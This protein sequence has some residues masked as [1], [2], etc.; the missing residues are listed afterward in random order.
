MGLFRRKGGGG[1]GSETEGTT[2]IDEEGGAT[3]AVEAVIT[4]QAQA[5]MLTHLEMMKEIVMK[6]RNEPGYAKNMYKECPR[7]QYL[8]E[9]NP[10]I[11]PVFE[12]PALVR[13]NFETVYREAGGVLPEEEAHAVLAEA[14]AKQK[15]SW[16]VRIANSPL[17]KLIKVALFFKKVIGCIAGG[18]IAAIGGCIACATDCCTD[19]CC[20][21]ALEQISV[22]GDG[23]VD[24]DDGDYDEM[25]FGVEGAPPDPNAEALN[26]AAEY[27]EDPDVQE[28]MQRLL[29]DPDNL[30]DAIENDTELRTLRDSNPLCAELMQDPETMKILVDPDNLRALGE[31]PQ[32]IELDFAD[33]NGFVPDTDFIDIEGGGGGG[34]ETFDV[35]FDP[36]ADLEFNPDAAAD[37]DFDAEFDAEAEAEELE[38]DDDDE[39]EGGDDNDNDNDFDDDNDGDDGDGDGDGDDDGNDDGDDDGAEEEEDDGGWEEDLEMEDQDI[40]ADADTNKQ[41]EASKGK[42]R[43]K[44]AAEK[45][46]AKAGGVKGMIA[47]MGVAATDLI[48]AQ[49]VGQIFGDDLPMADLLG[50]GGGDDI[51]LGGM[52]NVADQAGDVGDLVNDDIADVMDDTAAEVVDGKGEIKG[53]TGQNKHGGGLAQQDAMYDESGRKIYVAGGAAAAAVVAGGAIMVGTGAAAGVAGGKK[54]KYSSNRSIEKGQID[55]D[56]DIDSFASV[57]SNEDYDEDD[58]EDEGNDTKKDSGSD[59]DVDEEPK[60]PKSKKK[61]AFGFASHRFKEI[62]ASTVTQIKETVA[63]TFLGEDFGEMLVE[64]MEE[65]GDDDDDDEKEGDNSDDN[66]DKK[67]KKGKKSKKKK[68]H[69][70]DDDYV[71]DSSRDGFDDEDE[72]VTPKSKK[73]GF[74]FRKRK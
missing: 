27:M 63:T 50:G 67:K 56:D 68:K 55:D 29:E 18:G 37:A 7:L 61:K 74:S 42:Q 11:R 72:E 16:I 6:I 2:T 9:Q 60:K 43:K 59:D 14:K 52:D 54:G 65:G 15:K 33:P 49:V 35:D 53:N 38:W 36:D 10:D 40:D 39:M 73:G 13:I 41:T 3:V 31:A 5:V 25:E 66:K 4:E 32:M 64:R 22:D 24:L 57:N 1:S 23:S 47:S 70:D 21:D 45:Q 51:D 48:A 28:Q 46:A 12:D 71:E 34:L 44:S 26:H 20:E 30:A 58:F 62:A 8:L 69:D 19:C 17:F